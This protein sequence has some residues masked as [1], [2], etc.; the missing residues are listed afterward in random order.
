MD[1]LKTMP[2]IWVIILRTG[3]H[4]FMELKCFAQEKELSKWSDSPQN[5][6]KS[7]PIT[8]LTGHWYY[9]ELQELTTPDEPADDV[10]VNKYNW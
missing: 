1:F 4:N 3:P 10:M 2:V 7:L 6:R 8:C 9:K 5:W